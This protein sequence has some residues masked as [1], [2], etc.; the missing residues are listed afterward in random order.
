MNLMLTTI[1]IRVP[2]HQLMVQYC[3]LYALNML[4]R[5]G[6]GLLCC[7]VKLIVELVIHATMTNG[8]ACKNYD[9]NSITCFFI[10]TQFV[11][12]SSLFV[13]F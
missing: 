11:I 6:L 12:N 4:K 13:I 1:L 7:L 9:E 3:R 10:V 8:K 5:M 2:L